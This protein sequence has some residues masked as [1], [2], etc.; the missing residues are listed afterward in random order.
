MQKLQIFQKNKENSKVCFVTISSKY[1][2]N[3][4]VKECSQK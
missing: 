4:V 3:A 2:Y 1:K